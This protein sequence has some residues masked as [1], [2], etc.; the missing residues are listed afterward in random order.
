MP[1]ETLGPRR[2]A[3]GSHGP[4]RPE[5][6][7]SKP[8]PAGVNKGL[9]GGTTPPTSGSRAAPRRSVSTNPQ[10]A[11]PPMGAGKRKK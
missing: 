5:L 11:P 8:A 10:K 7:K 1:K 2:G 6:G 4:G 3:F 9:G